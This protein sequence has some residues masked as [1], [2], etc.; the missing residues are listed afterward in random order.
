MRETDISRS[1]SANSIKSKQALIELTHK[2]DLAEMLKTI[3]VASGSRNKLQQNVRTKFTEIFKDRMREV[4]QKLHQLW[5]ATSRYHK[6]TFIFATYGWCHSEHL[7]WMVQWSRQESAKWRIPFCEYVWR[8]HRGGSAE[9]PPTCRASMRATCWRRSAIRGKPRDF[10]V[11][12]I[13]TWMLAQ[14]S[15]RTHLLHRKC[16]K[17]EQKM[18]RLW[19]GNGHRMIA[20]RNK[21]ARS[22]AEFHSSA[23]YMLNL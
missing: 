22:L 14:V 15:Q 12:W 20:T 9:I 11:H 2:F 17:D 5:A 6:W 4:H 10:A 3:C 18:H 16:C 13:S 8:G 21:M 23:Q 19:I 1:K 7:L